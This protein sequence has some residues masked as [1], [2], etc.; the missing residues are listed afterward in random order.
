MSFS[1]SFLKNNGLTDEQIDAVMEEHLNVF[2]QLKAERDNWKTEA[3]KL[4]AIQSEL[5]ALKNGEDYKSKYDSEH[6]AFE[7]YKAN[8]AKEREL[9]KKTAEYRKLL[10]DEHVSE[11]RMDAVIRLTDFS[12][13]KLGKDGLEDA[14]K[15]R[16]AIR[17]DWGD[18][19]Q[20]E[21]VKGAEVD[22]PP[23]TDVSTFGTL[24]LAEKM[25]YANQHPN[26]PEV[27]EWLKK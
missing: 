8:I 27:T 7:E 2:N 24:S 1:R 20:T 14:D 15:L 13:M 16:E 23:K 26:A 25:A 17:S 11:K 6:S 9:E 22:T 19:I 3:E 4:P 12:Q 5:E 18:Y 10:R 21:V